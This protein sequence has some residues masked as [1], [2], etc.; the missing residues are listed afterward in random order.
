MTRFGTWIGSL[1]EPG[2]YRARVRKAALDASSTIEV[3]ADPE[4]EISENQRRTRWEAV[5]KLLTFVSAA[6][7]RADRTKQL[8]QQLREAQKDLESDEADTEALKTQLESFEQRARSLNHR[9]QRSHSLV[10]QLY[11][12]VEESPYLPTSIQLRRVYELE[13]RLAEDETVVDELTGDPLAALQNAL[14]EA[15]LSRLGPGTTK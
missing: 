11:R 4:L 6:K 1:S 8:H 14:A 7:P 9:V 12:N 2:V 13:A 15:G 3:E 5:D 10:Q